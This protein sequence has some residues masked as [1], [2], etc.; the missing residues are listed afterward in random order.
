MAQMEAYLEEFQRTEAALNARLETLSA[1]NAQLRSYSENQTSQIQALT[2]RLSEYQDM[3]EGN[4]DR[5]QKLASRLSSR[6]PISREDIV[7]MIERREDKDLGDK[8]RDLASRLAEE[9]RHSGK[10]K[11]KVRELQSQLMNVEN[12]PKGGSK[13]I[14]ANFQVLPL[15]DSLETRLTADLLALG[16]ELNEAHVFIA[17]LEQGRSNQEKNLSIES[18]LGIFRTATRELGICNYPGFSNVY[19]YSETSSQT[20]S[21]S[22]SVG[23][24]TE[25]HVPSIYAPSLVNRRTSLMSSVMV[26]LQTVSSVEKKFPGQINTSYGV[27]NPGRSSSLT[28]P[29]GKKLALPS[30][31]TPPT[32]AFPS[33]GFRRI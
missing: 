28:A 26:P 4:L 7:S 18:E 14:P 30:F 5:I 15:E 9:Q 33:F 6:E 8:N 23:I 24:Q 12:V 1:C 29:V 11:E 20:T 31:S 3:H 19:F 25:T 32:F 13:K 10:L 21:T 27:L 17:Q 16:K 2:C 22:S